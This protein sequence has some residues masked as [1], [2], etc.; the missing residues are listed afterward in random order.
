MYCTIQWLEKSIELL[1]NALHVL[2]RFLIARNQLSVCD[3]PKEPCPHLSSAGFG[4]QGEE[5]EEVHIFKNGISPKSINLKDSF[6]AFF[7]LKNASI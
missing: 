6:I 2:R 5:E 7:P 1:K 3:N 4:G